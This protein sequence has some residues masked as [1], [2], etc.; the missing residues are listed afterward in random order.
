MNRDSFR[1]RPVGQLCLTAIL[2]FYPSIVPAVDAH[3]F[4]PVQPE[5]PA[6]KDYSVVY[7]GQKI[8]FCCEICMDA[9][10]KNPRRYLANLAQSTSLGNGTSAGQTPS[11]QPTGPPHTHSRNYQAS[12][13]TWFISGLFSGLGKTNRVLLLLSVVSFTLLVLRRRYSRRQNLKPGVQKLLTLNTT[14]LVLFLSLAWM[15]YELREQHFLLVMKDNIHYTTY[16]DFGDPPVPV[17]PS[18]P[19]RIK[20][21]FYRGND[22]RSPLLFNGGNYRT[23]SFNISLHTDEG[24]EVH[25]GDDVSS[26][27]LYVR[28][29]IV[30][31][32][33]TPDFFFDDER[34]SNILFTKKADPFLGMMTPLDDGVPISNI[35]R[36][37]KW[38]ALY[39]IGKVSDKGAQKFEG[40]VYVAEKRYYD[41]IWRQSKLAGTRFHYAIQFDLLVEEGRMSL[42]SDMWMGA[43]YR[44]RRFSQWRLPLHEWFSHEPIPEISGKPTD[45]LKLLGVDEYAE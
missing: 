7:E 30:R 9:F 15:Y 44:T 19:K 29:E 24:K 43:L 31:A 8:D 3:T 32:A 21:T 27:K 22:E 38:E 23:C 5:K 45:D 33:N 18:V 37:R 34:M 10:S 1:A 11:N 36:L 2:V 16:Y 40:I 20:A 41:N 26:R 12:G 13:K 14:M 17:K 6:L 4:C 42:S 28:A 25:Y 35:E 39:P